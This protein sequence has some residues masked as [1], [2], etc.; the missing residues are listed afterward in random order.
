MQVNIR[1]TFRGFENGGHTA[2][3]KSGISW[4]RQD[5]VEL[6]YAQSEF[7]RIESKL[8]LRTEE[9]LW[10]VPEI[11]KCFDNWEVEIIVR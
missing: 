7:E 2:W 10:F 4:L 3:A 5:A 9:G 6:A 8:A 11:N 1:V